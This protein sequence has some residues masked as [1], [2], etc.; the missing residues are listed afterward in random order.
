MQCS[1]QPRFSRLQLKPTNAV[2]S[3]MEMDVD[4][5]AKNIWQDKLAEQRAWIANLP[6]LSEMIH[7][8]DASTAILT[9]VVSTRA[10]VQTHFPHVAVCSPDEKFKRRER[11][12]RNSMRG[13]GGRPRSNEEMIGSSTQCLRLEKFNLGIASTDKEMAAAGMWR[14]RRSLPSGPSMILRN[15]FATL[16]GRAIFY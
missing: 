5:W 8:K 14:A 3:S 6:T 15:V 13:R 9:S 10:P 11:K 4:M 16:P 1:R 7:R 12:F 2:D